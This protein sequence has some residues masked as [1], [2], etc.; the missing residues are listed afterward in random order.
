MHTDK[1]DGLLIL[2]SHVSSFY[3]GFAGYLEI[4]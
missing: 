3:L 4:A 2:V 1:K